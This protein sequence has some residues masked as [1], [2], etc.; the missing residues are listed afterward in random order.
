MRETPICPR[1]IGPTRFSRLRSP[2]DGGV[3][4][5]ED[6][7][8][9]QPLPREPVRR[10]GTHRDRN[11]PVRSHLLRSIHRRLARPRRREGGRP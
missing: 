4:W 9:P 6:V 5:D 3:D 8:D 2:V 11:R 1:T 7:P 10:M